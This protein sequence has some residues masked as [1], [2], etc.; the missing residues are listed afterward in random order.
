MF[1]LLKEEGASNISSSEDNILAKES[2]PPMPPSKPYTEDTKGNNQMFL[3]SLPHHFLQVQPITRDIHR[4]H[5]LYRPTIR[6][7][8]IPSY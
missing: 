3:S 5:S 8:A 7:W 1:E 6:V 4:N 2:T